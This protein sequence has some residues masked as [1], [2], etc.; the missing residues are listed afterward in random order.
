MPVIF[1]RKSLFVFLLLGWL[2]VFVYAQSGLINI[3]T[4]NLEELETL[5]RVG[6]TIAQRIIDGRPYALIE[7]I[8]RVQGIGGPGSKS[9]E[10]IKD[11]ITIGESSTNTEN[12]ADNVNQDTSKTTQTSSV[13]SSSGG[14]SAHYSA[15]PVTSV[16]S[17]TKTSVGAGRDR[18]GV[19]GSPLEFKVETNVAYNR[20]NIFSWNLG[21]GNIRGGDVF[22]HTYEYPGEYVVV[23]HASFPDGDAV[24]RV[25]VKIV[26]PELT[27]TFASGERIEITNGS[28]QEVNLFGRGLF[29]EG[30]TYIFPKDTI[31]K[32]KQ[33]ISF[34]SNMTGLVPASSDGVYI[35]VLGNNMATNDFTAQIAEQKQKKINTIS[36]ELSEI[37]E[38]LAL[39]SEAEEVVVKPEETI[40][41]KL[42]VAEEPEEGPETVLTASVVSGSEKSGFWGWLKRFF[43]RTER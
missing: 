2:P 9:Y 5:S 7:D 37:K 27:I 13:Q 42:T 26:A 21:D 29:Y 3:N 18:V 38:K 30:K 32:G 40:E 20:N 34:S 11:F 4:A 24:A 33:S 14:T 1:Y 15:T 31:L 41:A 6:P 39:Y 8:S 23:L 25:N 10:D 16:S 35:L 17:S 36:T 22:S 19:V 12:S 28:A 43:L